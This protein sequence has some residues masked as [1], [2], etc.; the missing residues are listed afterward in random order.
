[1]AWNLPVLAVSEFCKNLDY[2]KFGDI[3]KCF[4]EN[5]F[6]GDL[7]LAGIMVMVV[8]VALV[9]RFGFPLQLILPLGM[10]LTYTLYWASGGAT[11]FLALF[12]LTL[13]IGGGLLVVA[14]LNYVNR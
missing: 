3:G 14:I 6:F 1:M 5:S 9:V 11:I 8:F 7:T 10:A 12:M 13:I 4:I 2:T